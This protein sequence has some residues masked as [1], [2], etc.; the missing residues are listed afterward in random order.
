MLR[1]KTTVGLAVVLIGL[2]IF[3][4][5]YEVR[6]GPARE[7]AAAEKDRIFKGLEAADI[8]DVAITRKGETIRLKKSGDAWTLAA[9]VEAR[10]ERQPV[11]DLASSLAS[12]RIE[13]EIE[14]NPAKLADFGLEAPAVE[15]TFKAKG[16]EHRVRLGAK[17]PT[18]IWAYAQL[19]GKP[20]VVL[21]S[22]SL[23]RDAEKP[24]ADFRDR[25]VLAFERKDVKGL[26][27]KLPSGQTVAAQLKGSDEWQVTTPVAVPADREQ[28]SSLLEKLRAAKIK[29]FVT[30]APKTPEAYGLNRPL[31]L[32]LWLGEEKERVAKTLR[33]GKTIPD[34]KTAYAQREGDAT[35]FTVDEELVKAVPI[36]AVALR[37]KTVFTYDRGKLERVE[38]ES[39]KG[40]VVLL[41]EG[42]AWRITAPAQLK[43]DE[44]AMSD[45][46]WKAR[47]LRAKDF[48]AD[49]ARALAR[50][51]LDR[52]QVRLSVWEK[53]AK[54]PKALLLAPA[55]DKKDLA[56]ATV[57]GGGPA[58]PVV[59]VDAKALAELARSAQDLRDRSL[60]AGFDPKDVVR[61]QIQRG[62]QALVLERK[63]EEEWEFVA[64]RKGKARGS[65]VS[66]LIWTL[67]NLRWRD[68][69]AERGW[70]PAR[71]GLERP[72]TTIALA[73]KDGKTIAAL[74]VG[75]RDKDQAY[76]RVP[77]QP[78]LY[79]IETKNL[80]EIPAKPED[81]L[82]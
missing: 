66:D 19:E 11:Q 69:V 5:V 53:E 30:E 70:D 50:F 61:V 15:I 47:D 23:L 60:F 45:L 7:K 42:G 29:E 2:G 55:K 62:D 68:L 24:V 12:L 82:L 39:P 13:R 48:V 36:S 79:A 22:D 56:Y 75:T 64:P 14:A 40:K 9:P 80:G 72:A 8:E 63:G 6:Q 1:W 81:L 27:V 20:A 16:Q 76:V 17:N 71:Y 57:A 38:L 59:L 41:M 4:Y 25:T 35:V 77:D 49:D 51:G 18:G 3:V 26:E 52:P 37:D 34:K 44:G 58:S 31:R 43:V 10:A 46:L 67:R 28:I 78:A 33:L 73:D 21:V 74:A 32:T 54:E 65:R